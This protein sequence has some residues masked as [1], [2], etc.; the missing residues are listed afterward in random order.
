M[1]GEVLEASTPDE[2]PDLGPGSASKEALDVMREVRVDLAL[3]IAHRHGNR[4]SLRTHHW[5]YRDFATV[6]A[7]S[8]PS[9]R[10]AA[11]LRVGDDPAA[12]TA[13]TPF[14][15]GPKRARPATVT[16]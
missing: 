12:T 7:L 13:A 3:L 5:R 2:L 4:A 6:M 1:I 15:R 10:L 9:R 16:Q 14:A 8:R 11:I